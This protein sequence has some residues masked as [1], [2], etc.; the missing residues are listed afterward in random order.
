VLAALLSRRLRFSDETVAFLAAGAAVGGLAG[1]LAGGMIVTGLGAILGV[2]LL[3]LVSG[4]FCGMVFSLTGL[5]VVHLSLLKTLQ[6]LL[7]GRQNQRGGP[8]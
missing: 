1:A 8:T 4:L 3:G 7:E 5:M 6:I 2:G